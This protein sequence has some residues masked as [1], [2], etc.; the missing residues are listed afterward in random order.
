MVDWEESFK[1]K[2]ARKF[3][4]FI[5]FFV[6]RYYSFQ[7]KIVFRKGTSDAD[8]FRQVFIEKEYKLP[9]KIN[10]KLIID[11]G[12]NV[13]YSSLWFAKK[14]PTAEII[15]VEPEESNYK[16]LQEN[17]KLCK[18]IKTIKAGIWCKR[19]FLKIVNLSSGKWGFQTKEVNKNQKHDI[20]AITIKD[21]LKKADTK[22]IDILKLDIEGAEKELFS[23]NTS[24]LNKVNMI[25]IEFHDYFRKGCSNSFYSAINRRDWNE[26]RRGENV[27]L[28]RKKF[29]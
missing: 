21:I 25:I 6:I 2:I 3:Y 9:V 22:K 26:F 10:P 16:L 4:N 19:I 28:V 8:V 20:Q 23:K 13:G 1:E 18:N 14:F 11:C 17:T 24:W 12:A 27:I 7:N 5:T 15:A 29:L